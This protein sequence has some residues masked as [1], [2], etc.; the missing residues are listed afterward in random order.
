ITAIIN[1]ARGEELAKRWGLLNSGG[2]PMPV[3][4]IEHVKDLG[5]L[6]TE[7]W[8]MSETT[9]VGVGS[10]IL[11]MK[12]VGSIGVPMP[13]TDIRI[14]DVKE[15]IE[16]VKQGEPGELLIRSPLV[17]KEYF[18]CPE[19]TAGQLKDGWLSTGDVVA[20][21][22]DDYLF[23]VD[24][25]KDLVIAG[26]YNIYPRE[27]DEVLF[28][29]PKVL[30]AVSVGIPDAYRGE[31]MKA[32][33]VLKPGESAEAGEIIDFCRQRLAA[34][35]IPRSVEFRQSLPKSAVGK[36]L[37]KILRDEEA[38]RAKQADPVLR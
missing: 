37:R 8:G 31:T 12:K 11:G 22:R 34:Y 26:G 7:G 2:A 29:H 27:I 35:K 19:E 5:L 36:V 9:S 18:G 32:Y 17:M 15:G 28:E 4:L 21:D 13:D 33:V 25:K 30:E 14:V 24:R 16:E 3:E 38:A 1:D 6:F 20:R 23:I 10:P